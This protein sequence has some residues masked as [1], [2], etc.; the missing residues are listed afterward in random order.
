MTSDWLILV[1]LSPTF[2]CLFCFVHPIFCSSQFLPRPL[3]WDMAVWASI[4][5]SSPDHL[6][7]TV[8]LQRMLHGLRP[9]IMP[10]FLSYGCLWADNFSLSPTCL[11]L[12][13]CLCLCNYCSW[14]VRISLISTTYLCAVATLVSCLF[15]NCL[16]SFSVFSPVDTRGHVAG[17]S[18]ALD[19]SFVCLGST[20]VYFAFSL[21]NDQ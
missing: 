19:M 14:H 15:S 18:S 4:S 11:F 20:L 5:T 16:Y 8:G 21:G 1:G 2:S 13:F 6:R 12:V 9:N 7:R 10:P 3:C 17:K